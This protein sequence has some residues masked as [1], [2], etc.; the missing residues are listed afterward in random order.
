MKCEGKFRQSHASFLSFPAFWLEK[1]VWVGLTI[2]TWPFKSEGNLI[3]S[4]IFA[5]VMSA[6]FNA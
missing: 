6:L 3:Q 4:E 2:G 1:K 5:K